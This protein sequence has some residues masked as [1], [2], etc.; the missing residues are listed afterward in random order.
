MSYDELLHVEGEP[1]NKSIF[2]HS[3]ILSLLNMHMTLYVL[4]SLKTR[5]IYILIVAHPQREV[6]TAQLGGPGSP[7]PPLP[8]HLRPLPFLPAISP[9]R[10][11]LAGERLPHPVHRHHRGIAGSGTLRHPPSGLQPLQ[12]PHRERE[13]ERFA[14]EGD[15]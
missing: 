1:G 15:T 9:P 3:R 5:Y 4:P 6:K 2:H 8:Q 14:G 13:S 12:T 10:L 11:L 7:G